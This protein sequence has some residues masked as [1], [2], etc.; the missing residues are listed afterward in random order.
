MATWAPAQTWSP[1]E[2]ELIQGLDDCYAAYKAEN[3][4]A[5]LACSHEDSV[6][7]RYGMPGTSSKADTRKNLPLFWANEDMV[8]YW[9]NPLA[10][11]IIGDVAI[12]HYYFYELVRDK[13]GKETFRRYRWT[14]IMVKQDGK[15]VWIADHGGEDPGVQPSGQ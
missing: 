12:I 10:I 2:K 8:E 1:A 7:F 14:D 11:R 4:E 13:E 5:L 3:L 9:I 15:W 6:V